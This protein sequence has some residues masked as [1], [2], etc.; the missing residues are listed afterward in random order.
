M[1][2]GIFSKY[3]GIS[4]IVVP[5][6]KRQNRTHKKKRINK[7]WAKRY[8]YTLYN[9]IEDEKVITMNGTMYMNPRTYYKIQG[10]VG[11]LV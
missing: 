7:K 9:S 2:N 1:N 3:T 4:I 10:L 11:K 5:D 6:C 8:G